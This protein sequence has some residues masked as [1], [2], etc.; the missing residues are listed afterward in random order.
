MHGIFFKKDW[1][2]TLFKEAYGYERLKP[3]HHVRMHLPK[4]FEDSQV[5]VDTLSLSYFFN[6]KMNPKS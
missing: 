6:L 1:P 2:T 4:Q 5:W 3:K